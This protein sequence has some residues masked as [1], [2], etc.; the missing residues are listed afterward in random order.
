MDMITG[1]E[2]LAQLL[3]MLGQ[4]A[5]SWESERAQGSTSQQAN[6]GAAVNIGN[7]ISQIVAHA[8]TAVPAVSAAAAAPSVTIAAPK[9]STPAA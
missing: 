3:G 1:A 6:I 5:I 4:V 2:W 7:A 9:S 8:A